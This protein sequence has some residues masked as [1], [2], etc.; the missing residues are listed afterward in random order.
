MRPHEQLVVA[1]G[2]TVKLEPEGLHVMLMG[3]PPMTATGQKL[4][5]TF[6]LADGNKIEVAAAVRPLTAQ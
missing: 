5:L 2:Q 4:V 6:Q 3:V 1:P